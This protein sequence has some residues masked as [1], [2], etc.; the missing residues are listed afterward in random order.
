[1][2]TD[3]GFVEGL[4]GGGGEGHFWEGGGEVWR[5]GWICGD[6]GGVLFKGR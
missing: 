3:F 5:D 1:M 4:D 2:D 6:E